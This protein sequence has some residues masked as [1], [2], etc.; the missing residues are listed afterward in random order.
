MQAMLGA[1][2]GRLTRFNSEK[3]KEIL[4]FIAINSDSMTQE[5]I[6]RMSG[7]DSLTGKMGCA[8]REFNTAM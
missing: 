4:S 7:D 1:L 5:I 6:L 2:K 3:Q 8:Q